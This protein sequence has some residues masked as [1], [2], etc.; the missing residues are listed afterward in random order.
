MDKHLKLMPLVIVFAFSVKCLILGAQWT[1][2][3]FLSVLSGIGVYFQQTIR[4]DKID[5]F[6]ERIVEM[7]KKLESK[8]KD[9]DDVRNYFSSLKLA[10]TLR[11]AQG[12]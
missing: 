3:A 10:Q 5:N 11:S 12:K 9:I 7:E 6:E 4:K 8:A 2:V 1:D